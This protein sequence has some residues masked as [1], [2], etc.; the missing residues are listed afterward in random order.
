MNLFI[1]W[2]THAS[3]L[4]LNQIFDDDCYELY[5]HLINTLSVVQKL[6]HLLNCLYVMDAI[7]SN[8]KWLHWF[9]THRSSHWILLQ[10]W[11][12]FLWRELSKVLEKCSSVFQYLGFGFGS[13]NIYACTTKPRGCR[14]CCVMF[15]R[16][17][18]RRSH[19]VASREVQIKWFWNSHWRLK[20]RIY[21]PSISTILFLVCLSHVFELYES[22]ILVVDPVKAGTS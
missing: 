19:Q 18:D 1:V 17:G 4:T 6:L 8:K 21:W 11:K 3:E 7:P 15:T 14:V 9:Y 22:A 10:S 20:V 5:F 12:C 2:V 16:R 13:A